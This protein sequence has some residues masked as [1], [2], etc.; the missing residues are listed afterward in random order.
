MQEYIVYRHGW[1]SVN[2]DPHH[3]LPKKQPVL[4]VRA[5]GPEEA[6]ELARPQVLVLDNQHLTAEPAA[7]VDAKEDLMNRTARGMSAEP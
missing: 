6:C 2:Q 1:N 3:G 7:P 4:R 5:D